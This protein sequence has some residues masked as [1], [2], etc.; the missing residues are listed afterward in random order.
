MAV[1]LSFH[2]FGV[3]FTVE[4]AMPARVLRPPRRRIKFAPP[5]GGGVVP[6]PSTAIRSEAACAVSPASSSSDHG[7]WRPKYRTRKSD[8]CIG[9]ASC[10]VAVGVQHDGGGWG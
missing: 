5:V 10:P 9:V 1:V 8:S 6:S 3:G 7:R 4:L 2:S